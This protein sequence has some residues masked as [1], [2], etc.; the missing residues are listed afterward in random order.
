ME[1]SSGWDR[2]AEQDA[3][4]LAKKKKQEKIDKG[5]NIAN[6]LAFIISLIALAIAAAI[7]KVFFG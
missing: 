1:N 3:K 6:G 2:V 4:N 5:F 7:M